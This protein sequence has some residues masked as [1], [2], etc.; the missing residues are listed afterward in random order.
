MN[1]PGSTVVSLKRPRASSG[2]HSAPV[3]PKPKLIHAI[4]GDLKVPITEVNAK[5]DPLAYTYTLHIIDEPGAD[6]QSAPAPS[7][8][9]SADGSINVKANNL[10]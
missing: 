3:P 10:R 4:N 1:P 9:R 5:D 2:A 6:G 8:K 7:V